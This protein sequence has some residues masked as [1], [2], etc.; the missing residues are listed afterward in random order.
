MVYAFAVLFCLARHY[1]TLCDIVPDCRAGT[2]SSRRRPHGRRRIAMCCAMNR[3]PLSQGCE[4]ARIHRMEM[5]TVLRSGLCHGVVFRRHRHDRDQQSR[6]RTMRGRSDDGSHHLLAMTGSEPVV[7]LLQVALIRL[8]RCQQDCL[9]E[10]H[11]AQLR[12]NLAGVE[13]G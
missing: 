6:R 9:G 3:P 7:A 2:A 11:A 1:A 10:T 4:R 13:A 5:G 12:G 8:L